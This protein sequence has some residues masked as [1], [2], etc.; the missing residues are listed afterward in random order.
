MLPVGFEPTISTGERL[1]SY[2]LDRTA[3]GTNRFYYTIIITLLFM[4]LEST[5]ICAVNMVILVC[6]ID[7]PVLAGMA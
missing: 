1:Q 5:T 2:A 7:C 3:S 4:L 6:R